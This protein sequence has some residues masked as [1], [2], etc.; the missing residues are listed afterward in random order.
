MALLKLN[1]SGHE[2]FYIET[3]SVDGRYALESLNEIRSGRFDGKTK[4]KSDKCELNTHGEG[5]KSKLLLFK[6]RTSGNHLAYPKYFSRR[7]KYLAR[8]RPPHSV[9]GC[10]RREVNF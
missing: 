6:I 5:S 2:S 7:Y 10:D 9:A 4:K 8:T 1:N 3:T